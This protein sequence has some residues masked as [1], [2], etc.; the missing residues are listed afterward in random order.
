MKT[1]EILADKVRQLRA[2][3]GKSQLEFAEDVGI[4]KTELIQIEGAQANVRLDTLEQLAKA[5]HAPVSSLLAE[6]EDAATLAVAKWLL[7]SLDIVSGLKPEDQ[8]LAVRLFEEL[9]ILMRPGIEKTIG[10]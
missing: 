3:Q 5:F 2:L 8:T 9:V 1:K 6:E 4:S 7:T 10:K